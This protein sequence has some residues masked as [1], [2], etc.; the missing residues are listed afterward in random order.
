M[1]SNKNGPRVLFLDIETAPN[2][3]WMW[4]MW[5]EWTSTEMQSESWYI[6]CICS[7]W[8]GDKNVMSFAL[9][10]YPLY[11]KEQENDIE[12]LKAVRKLL[13][14]ADIVV[15]H[16]AAAFDIKKINARFAKHGIPPPSP[17]KVVDTLLSARKN[18]AFTSN[19]LA[20]LGKYL[21]LGQ[22]V[23]TGGFKLWKQCMAG[24]KSAW[25]KMVD[26]CKNDVV[27]LEKV[28]L[29]LLPYME[30]HPN[31]GIYFDSDDAKCP[32]CGK[33]TLTKNGFAYN[34]SAKYQRYVCNSCGAWSRGRKNLAS[35]TKE[36]LCK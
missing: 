15:G 7:R 33:E 31:C 5:Q 20:D 12:I 32:N 4:S 36:R 10:D 1:K 35:K 30:S 21:G 27:L 6:L 28:Y 17:Y 8:L 23:E 29:K 34:N 22:K 13:D 9:P 3:V 26:Y 16:N 14:E 24:D 18:F 2:L 25:K 19:K 11:K